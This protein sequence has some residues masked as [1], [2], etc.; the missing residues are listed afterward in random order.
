MISLAISRPFGPR[1]E[2]ARR[3]TGR[4]PCRDRLYTTQ[5][6]LQALGHW[7]DAACRPA[8]GGGW[9]AGVHERAASERELWRFGVGVR[10]GFHTSHFQDTIFK[11]FLARAV[12]L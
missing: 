6:A 12:I 4:R 9:H 1:D 5:V 3:V 2:S 7:P 11:D 10:R 8:R